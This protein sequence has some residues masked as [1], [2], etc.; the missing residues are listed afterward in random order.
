V[1][2]CGDAVS[3][4]SSLSLPMS[5]LGVFEGLPGVLVSRQVL[6]LSVLLGGAMGVCSH[7]V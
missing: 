3:N 7:V 5:V 6:L 4:R 1:P 2:E